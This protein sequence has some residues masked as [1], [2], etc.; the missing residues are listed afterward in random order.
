MYKKKVAFYIT[1]KII[2]LF[3]ILSTFKEGRSYIAFFLINKK[4]KM[5][6]GLGC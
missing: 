4:M 1:L 5:K 2:S 6:K 3:S